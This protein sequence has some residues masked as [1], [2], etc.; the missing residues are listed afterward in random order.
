LNSK[1]MYHWVKMINSTELL[2]NL[3]KKLTHLTM[4]HGKL[5]I[6]LLMS[7]Q[8]L[9]LLFIIVIQNNKHKLLAMI[10]FILKEDLLK[11]L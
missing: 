7:S 2:Q 6:Q 11:L 10:Q 5:T 8:T 3:V 9:I 1:T 4:S